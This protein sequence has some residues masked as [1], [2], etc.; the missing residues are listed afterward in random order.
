MPC[1][2][3]TELVGEHLLF[4]LK[5]WCDKKRQEEYANNHN[6]TGFTQRDWTLL[7]VHADYM[8][9]TRGRTQKVP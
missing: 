9:H 3:R 6:V 7:V 8:L 5:L 1:R 4:L 2:N